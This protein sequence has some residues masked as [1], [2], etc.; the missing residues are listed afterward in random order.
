[1]AALQ[2]G[3]TLRRRCERRISRGRVTHITSFPERG[4]NL[5]LN[6]LQSSYLLKQA[7]IARG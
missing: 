3:W 1:M 7:G 5:V 6:R 4:G 2:T